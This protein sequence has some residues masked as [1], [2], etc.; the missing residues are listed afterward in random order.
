[1]RTEQGFSLIELLVALL[2]VGLALGALVKVTTQQAR[3]ASA[4]TERTLAHWAGQNLLLEMEQ[5]LYQA[6]AASI[7]MGP[8]RFNHQI[9]RTPSA[10]VS[11]VQIKLWRAEQRTEHSLALVTGWTWP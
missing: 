11:Q 2:I 9:Q 1:M 4:I 10:G 8:Y 3:Q 5:G 6:H 7:R